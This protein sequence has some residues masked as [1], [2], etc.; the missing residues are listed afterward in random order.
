MKK[1]TLRNDLILIGSLLLVAVIALVVVLTTRK[2]DNLVA[3]VSVQSEIVLT[4]DLE[5]VNDEHYY[6]DGLHDKVHIHVKD[7]SI[8]VVESGCPHQDCVHMGY[9]SET[10]RP[11]IC[12]YNAICIVIEGASSTNDVNIG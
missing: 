1:N 8:A 4:I 6:V 11:I 9:V 12:T 5:K 7:K 2:K 3:K 10:N